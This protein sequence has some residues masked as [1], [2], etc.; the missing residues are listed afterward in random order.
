MQQHEMIRV[1]VSQVIR[2]TELI[3][4]F[5]DLENQAHKT[6]EQVQVALN[7]THIPGVEFS[8]P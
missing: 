5:N 6:G 8:A 1:L 3:G 2:L 4:Q 7:E